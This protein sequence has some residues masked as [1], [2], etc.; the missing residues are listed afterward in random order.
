MTFDDDY[1][2]LETEAGIKRPTLKS[3]G[4]EWPPP[5]ELNLFGFECRRIRYSRITDEQREGLDFVLRGAEY[6]F[7][8]E[9]DNA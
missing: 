2:H 6:E 5:E 9:K 7:I 4:L 8:Q 3:L 1:I